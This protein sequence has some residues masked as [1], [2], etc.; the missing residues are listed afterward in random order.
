GS[1]NYA[2]GMFHDADDLV[3]K[4]LVL[5]DFEPIEEMGGKLDPMSRELDPNCPYVG[6]RPFEKSERL[7]FLTRDSLIRALLRRIEFGALT[8]VFGASGAGKTSLLRAGVL[9]D[10]LQK[11]GDDAKVIKPAPSADPYE[12]LVAGFVDAGFNE[13]EVRAIAAPHIEDPDGAAGAVSSDVFGDLRRNLLD[14]GEKWL[15]VIDPFEE[16][17]VRGQRAQ[18]LLTERFAASIVSFEKDAPDD[19]RMIVTI[20]DDLFGVIQDHKELYPVI[21]ANLFRIPDIRGDDL[22]QIIEEPAA[23]QGVMF[24]RGLVDRIV[25]EVTA[26]PGLLP[27]MQHALMTLWDKSDVVGRM[28]TIDVHESIGGVE[29]ALANELD[30]FYDSLNEHEQRTVRYMLLALVDVSE[31]PRAAR[32]VSRS[33]SREEL[34]GIGGETMLQQLLDDPGIVRESVADGSVIELVHEAAIEGWPRFA[35][36]VRDRR[37]ATVLRLGLQEDATRWESFRRKSEWADARQV[38]WEGSKLA[39]VEELDSAGD[40]QRV[41]G[42]GPLERRFLD[43]CLHRKENLDVI[44]LRQRLYESAERWRWLRRK[45]KFVKAR[46][47]LW[48]GADLERA[49]ECWRGGQFKVLADYNELGN[50]ERLEKEFI[51]VSISRRDRVSRVWKLRFWIAALVALLGIFAFSWPW[52]NAGLKRMGWDHPNVTKSLEFLEKRPANPGS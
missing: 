46:S 33:A 51:R 47:E 16:M 8:T 38:L 45:R 20:R 52:M 42:I 7:Q 22:R 28:L 6:L 21:D 32:P 15:I 35:T 34:V 24:E 25:D 41:G 17:F 23:G 31:P 30:T 4:V 11:N 50:L 10:W 12:G 1:H 19:I 37:E 26:R 14:K 9:R 5:E 18:R 2:W 49:D 48:T 44:E 36:W 3:E 43:A 39:K 29:H 27:L 13:D 40:F